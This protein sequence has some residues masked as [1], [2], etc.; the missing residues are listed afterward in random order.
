M[1]PTSHPF[2]KP[3]S[4]EKIFGNWDLEIFNFEINSS[5][6]FSLSLECLGC[7]ICILI[8]SRQVALTHRLGFN[9]FII[10]KNNEF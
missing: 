6:S 5:A 10:I 2:G 1:S 8:L 7:R 3:A 4:L 9:N